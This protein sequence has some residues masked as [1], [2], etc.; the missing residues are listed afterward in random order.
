VRVCVCVCVLGVCVCMRVCVCVCFQ[1]GEIEALLEVRALLVRMC[2]SYM[3]HPQIFA[4][5]I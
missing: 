2:H 1:W 4:C 5:R 3:T